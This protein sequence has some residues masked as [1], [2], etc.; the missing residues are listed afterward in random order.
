MGMAEEEEMLEMSEGAQS[1]DPGIG[2]IPLRPSRLGASP[3]GKAKSKVEAKSK[4]V[5]KN[6]PKASTPQ[7]KQVVVPPW[8]RDGSQLQI[9][10]GQVSDYSDDAPPKPPPPKAA[11]VASKPSSESDSDGGVRKR[12]NPLS[13]SKARPSGAL[14]V[15]GR[16]GASSD[17]D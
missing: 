7:S 15:V 17:S 8:M 11:D 13:L 6:V 5:A 12:K 16:A 3:K 2:I 4:A 9:T 1:S 10:E 14:G